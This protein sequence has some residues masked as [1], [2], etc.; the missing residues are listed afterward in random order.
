MFES[1]TECDKLCDELSLA[2]RIIA[3]ADR[4]V[5]LRKTSHDGDEIQTALEA[6]YA[7][8]AELEEE[9]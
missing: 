2:K 4:F 1:R 9:P 8:R 6:Y 7:A 3:A 5:Y